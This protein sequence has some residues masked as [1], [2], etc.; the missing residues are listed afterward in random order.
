[1]GSEAETHKTSLIFISP[2]LARGTWGRRPPPPLV[3]NSSRGRMTSLTFFP[4]VRS[5]MSNQVLDGW[6]RA[7][8]SSEQGRSTNKP[9]SIIIETI[10]RTPL[11]FPF[12]VWSSDH[13]M[14]TPSALSSCCTKDCQR[15]C[16]TSLLVVY[17]RTTSLPLPLPPF[18]VK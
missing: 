16:M 1:M 4:V 6:T 5:A 11:G 7:K 13:G 18:H 15:L 10:I 8:L 14:F 9:H 17:S 12:I 3:E 2:R